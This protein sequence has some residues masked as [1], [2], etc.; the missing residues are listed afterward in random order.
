[1][2]IMGAL[3]HYGCIS[4]TSETRAVDLPARNGI[5]TQ[6]EPHGRNFAVG[7]RMKRNYF[8]IDDNHPVADV[9][10]GALRWGGGEGN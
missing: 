3:L 2:P 9:S 4:P 1:M 10:S 5:P 7:D 8:S 6:L